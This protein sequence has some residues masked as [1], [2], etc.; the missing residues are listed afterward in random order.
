MGLDSR[1]QASH[2]T[3]PKASQGRIA[4]MDFLAHNP[5]LTI[6]GVI[7]LGAAA[8]WMAW[9]VRLPAI[10]P[11]LIIGFLV[12]PVLNL[13]NPSELI[14]NDLLFPAVSLAVGLILFEGGLTLRFPEVANTR[15]VVWRLISIGSLITWLGCA[16]AGYFL[17]GLSLPL[18]FLF[19]ALI[20][21]TGPTVIGPLLRNVR[22]T[23]NISNILKWEGILIDP[24]GALVAVLVFE[25]LLIDN[26]TEAITQTI[27]TFI[28]VIVVGT[29]LG[30]I[31]GFLLTQ[32]L[33][34]RLLPE[35]LVNV[36]SLAFVFMVFAVSNTVFHESGLLAVTLMGMYISNRNVPNFEEILSFKEDLVL[37]F[38]SLLFIIL[39]ANIQLEVFLA[40][41]SWQS[42]A[43]IGIVMLVVRPINIFVSTIGSSISFKEKLF[44]SWIAPRGI[45]AASVS[46]LFAFE[47]SHEGY[48]GASSVEALVFLVIVGTV[49][50]NSITA[51]PLA[52]YLGVAEPDPQGFL[53]LG[54]HPFARAI[55][56]FLQDED[57]NVMLADINWA[58]VA[59]ARVD[60]LTAYYGSLLSESSD[61]EVSLSGIG[62]LLALTQNDEANALT[63]L[64]FAREFGSQAVYQLAPKDSRNLRKQIGEEQ[65]GRFLFGEK[66]SFDAV[67][68]LYD[69][70]AKLKKINITEQFS[71]DDFDALYEDFLPMFVIRGGK[72]E[73]ITEGSSPPEAGDVLVSLVLEPS[74]ESVESPSLS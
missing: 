4:P 33:K 14:G 54:A 38:I 45:V 61:D 1:C 56:R 2:N 37:L 62:K 72:A 13:V 68:D 23:A 63:A 34:R 16:A 29:L 28:G 11:L 67:E 74:I 57:F 9:R 18:A 27:L 6:A 36:T 21:V 69:Q 58:N 41:L 64:K 12:G 10:L 59:A 35:Y 51:K 26:R 49:I 22:P 17:A 50:L 31:G 7:A 3:H 20:I 48:V 24:V 5:G 71:F 60:G 8:Q 15:K 43:V 19:G 30:L 66:A 70:G 52:R 44:L 39:A 55:A 73:V 25:Y 46:A 47:L 53:I 42:L 32:I 40:V 65:R